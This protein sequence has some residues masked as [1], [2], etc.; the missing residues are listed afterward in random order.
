MG[1]ETKHNIGDPRNMDDGA[2]FMGISRSRICW[3]R[4]SEATTS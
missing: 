2:K 1:L 3:G 4:Y